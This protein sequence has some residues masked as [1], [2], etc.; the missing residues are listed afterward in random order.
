MAGFLPLGSCIGWASRRS[1]NYVVASRHSPHSVPGPATSG[2]EVAGGDVEVR[3]GPA[4]WRSRGP[5]ERAFGVIDGTSRRSRSGHGPDQS[6]RMSPTPIRRSAPSSGGAGRKGRPDAVDWEG[7]GR[8]PAALFPP[9][10][11]PGDER[12]PRVQARRGYRIGASRHRNTGWPPL[13]EPPRVRGH[14]RFPRTGGMFRAA[15]SVLK[16]GRNRHR[17]PR[18][19]YPPRQ[20]ERSPFLALFRF[21]EIHVSRERDRSPIAQPTIQLSPVARSGT[22]R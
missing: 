14:R 6:L 17:A 16:I 10:P 7:P 19:Q 4:R 8:R 2:F 3:S 18:A 15:G 21:H 5:G 13:P 12:D 11:C 9:R 22:D 1:A 20:R